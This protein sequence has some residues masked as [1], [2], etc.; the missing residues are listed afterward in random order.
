[1]YGVH[2]MNDSECVLRKPKMY[3]VTILDIWSCDHTIWKPQF[4]YII[5]VK[6]RSLIIIVLNLLN[7]ILYMKIYPN[8]DIFGTLNVPMTCENIWSKIFTK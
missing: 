7:I 1:M 8:C 3:H 2:Y 5:R 6:F 4:I